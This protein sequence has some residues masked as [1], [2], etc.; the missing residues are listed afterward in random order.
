MTSIE[1]AGFPK[2][3]GKSAR[4]FAAVDSLEQQMR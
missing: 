4:D 2:A 1:D 3:V